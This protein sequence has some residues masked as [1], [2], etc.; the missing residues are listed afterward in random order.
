MTTRRRVALA[1]SGAL[2][3]MS[4]TL[5]AQAADPNAADRS[6]P[7]YSTAGMTYP[8]EDITYPVEQLHFPQRD[9]VRRRGGEREEVHALREGALREGLRE[10]DLR[11]RRPN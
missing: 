10:T 3:L 8:V 1:A 4:L 7:E 11:S 5:P 2:V 6:S 9:R